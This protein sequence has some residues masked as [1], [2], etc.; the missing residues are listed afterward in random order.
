MWVQGHVGLQCAS[1]N[2]HGFPWSHVVP[3]G[4][5]VPVPR[6]CIVVF[7][8]FL[9]ICLSMYI[10]HV[11]LHRERTDAILPSRRGTRNR[12]L[13]YPW[14][15]RNSWTSGKLNDG[16]GIAAAFTSEITYKPIN[17]YLHDYTPVPVTR[18]E[19]QPPI[20]VIFQ[21]CKGGPVRCTWTDLKW[22]IRYGSTE[23]PRPQR[24]PLTH[25]STWIC[26]TEHVR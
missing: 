7:P 12:L 21:M 17:N 15:A 6:V 9:S 26:A 2:H 1:A 25:R 23:F 8:C 4:F 22:K 10:N 18:M 20:G 3:V 13:H 14:H 11:F 16:L 5:V 19:E 24:L